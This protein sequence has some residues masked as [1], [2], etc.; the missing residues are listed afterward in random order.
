V[1]PFDS[2]RDHV[3]VLMYQQRKING[4]RTRISDEIAAS[5]NA[6]AERYGAETFDTMQYALAQQAINR[7]FAKHYGRFRGDTLC[8]LYQ[9]ITDCT[10]YAYTL[11]IARMRAFVRKALADEPELLAELVRRGQERDA[12]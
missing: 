12:A 9:A 3:R 1:D 10:H 8:T 7:V 4:I 2:K 11:A 6:N 5:L